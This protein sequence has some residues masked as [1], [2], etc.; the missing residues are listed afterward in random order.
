MKHF[1]RTLLLRFACAALVISRSAGA[2]FAQ[3][4]RTQAPKA[5]LAITYLG[6]RSL[7]AGSSQSFWMQGGAAE[8]GLDAWH[9][10]GVAADITGT[11]SSSVGSAGV[12]L[13]I[14]TATFGPRY[15][16]HG[17]RKTSLYGEGMLGEANGFRSL[18]P[19]PAGAQSGA[20]SLAVQ[21]GGGL[22]LTLR[23]HF[24]IRAIQAAWI[25]TQ[26]P[27]ATNNVQNTL[28]LG[29]GLVI[30]FGR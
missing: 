25:R 29:L 22:D 26:L 13:S 28:Q 5:D 24:A 21:V 14:V 12:P 17:D 6:E 20:N 4:P 30:R 1:R 9:G 7:L 23:R 18:F 15:R 2:T 10:W 3:T 16:W 8:L 19:D 27:N 11:H